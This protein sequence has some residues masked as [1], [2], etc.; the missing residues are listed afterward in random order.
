MLVALV[1][2]RW[3]E[4]SQCG[5]FDFAFL[6]LS[7]DAGDQIGARLL[8]LIRDLVCKLRPLLFSLA[9]VGG[10]CHGAFYCGLWFWSC[11]NDT[12]LTTT[13]VGARLLNL[14]K[15]S[16]VYAAWSFRFVLLSAV[17]GIIPLL[18][19]CGVGLA[20]LTLV[21][22]GTTSELDHLYYCGT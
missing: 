19:V 16:V 5:W 6:S 17:L 3:Y 4:S 18:L 10:P 13:T 21:L 9:L 1:G 7:S 8:N 14:I 15:G 11:H 2:G 12:S 20:T 22:R